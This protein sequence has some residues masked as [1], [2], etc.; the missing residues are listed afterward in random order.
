MR[1]RNLTV[2]LSVLMLLMLA[3][4]GSDKMQPAVEPTLE[5]IQEPTQEPTQEPIPTM[6]VYEVYETEPPTE[7]PVRIEMPEYKFTYSGELKDSIVIKELQDSGALEFTVKISGGEV[8]IFTLYFNTI[9]GDFVNMVEDG[10]GNKIPV[11]FKMASVPED[12]SDAE[13]QLFYQAQESV[14]EIVASLTLK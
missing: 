5:P 11:A 3:G 13:I 9:D 1:V 10:A 8:H 2:L 7:Q 4:C 14:N 12:L 6:V